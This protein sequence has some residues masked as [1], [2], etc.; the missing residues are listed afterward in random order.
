MVFSVFLMFAVF[1]LLPPQGGESVAPYQAF[2]AHPL[3]QIPETLHIMHCSKSLYTNITPFF[4]ALQADPSDSAND[5]K[6][7]P[8]SCY[9]N[10]GGSLAL[11][12]LSQ[13]LTQSLAGGLDRS[14]SSSQNCRA[15]GF[16]VVR[17]LHFKQAIKHMIL[18]LAADVV[19]QAAAHKPN[20]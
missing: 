1:R 7:A 3:M 15:F 8:I 14:L 20:T 16:T 12:V 13:A 4:S 6:T 18:N 10:R 2:G 11:F 19:R 17:C 5:T 9:R